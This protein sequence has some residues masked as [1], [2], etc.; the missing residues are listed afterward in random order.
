MTVDR[1]CYR[2]PGEIGK[3]G[4]GLQRTSQE[5]TVYYDELTAE[6]PISFIEDPMDCE[7]W[8]GWAE[9]TESLGDRIQ[10]SGRSLYR[11]D[12]KR[13]EKGIRMAS[14]KCHYCKSRPG[15][16][17]DRI[18]Q[19]DK[20]GTESRI[21]RVTRTQHRRDIRQSDRR[22]CCCISVSPGYRQGGSAIWKTWKN[23]PAASN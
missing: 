16:D 18:I 19:C 12:I 7:D 10:L 1:K 14:S 5:M 6:F 9:I 23:T 4:R 13:L 3:K 11:T 2:F 8:D 21:R 22:S 15:R 20:N 17:S